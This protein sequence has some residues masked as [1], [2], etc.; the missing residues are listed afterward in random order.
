MMWR[1]AG[2]TDVN[3]SLITGHEICEVAE[4]LAE[5]HISMLRRTLFEF[6]LQISAAVLIFAQS[7]YFSLQILQTGTCKAV[8]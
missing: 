7:R 1:Q 3:I 4:G 5:Y 2:R 8:D 6:F